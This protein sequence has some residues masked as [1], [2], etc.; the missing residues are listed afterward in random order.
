MMELLKD[1]VEYGAIGLVAVVALGWARRMYL[2]MK[3]M[4]ETHQ[5]DIQAMR[6]AFAEEREMYQQSMDA[7]RERLITKAETWVTKFHDQLDAQTKV[8]D[9]LERRWGR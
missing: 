3:T 4:R 5:A 6:E 8:M 7:L 9:A 1:L 2:D